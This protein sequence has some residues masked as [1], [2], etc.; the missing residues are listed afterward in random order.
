M[1]V[2]RFS[3]LRG[4]PWDRWHN[5]ETAERTA[6]F[7]AVRSF[8]LKFCGD[9]V[10]KIPCPQAHVRIPRWGNDRCRGEISC[11]EGIREAAGLAEKNGQ[12]AVACANV[13]DMAEIRIVSAEKINHFVPEPPMLH[14]RR[15]GKIFP[16]AGR[17]RFQR[18]HRFGADL[19]AVRTNISPQSR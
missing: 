4:I 3:W 10:S 18:G 5:L 15:G 17:E 13:H 12:R 14:L 8:H 2:S 19:F 16:F 9:P 7:A 1:R 11:P 6:A